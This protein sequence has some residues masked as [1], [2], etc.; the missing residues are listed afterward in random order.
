MAERRL[1]GQPLPPLLSLL[2]V[3]LSKVRGTWGDHCSMLRVS[4]WCLEP[5]HVQSLGTWGLLL[6]PCS[7]S[8]PPSTCGCSP[9]N[10]SP[11][12]E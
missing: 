3:T 8:Q 11:G 9:S 6:C 2:L 12:C 5:P 1:Q 10:H 4:V 7:K